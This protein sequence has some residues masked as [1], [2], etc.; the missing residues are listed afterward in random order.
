[1]L[2]NGNTINS[3][4][5]NNDPAWENMEQDMEGQ[6][7]AFDAAEAANLE[8]LDQAVVQEDAMATDTEAA[9][10]A[11]ATANLAESV[12]NPTTS[13][14][15]ITDE[16]LA[17]NLEGLE[18]AEVQSAAEIAAVET[19]PVATDSNTLTGDT[20]DSPSTPETAPKTDLEQVNDIINKYSNPDDVNRSEG[21]P[22]NIRTAD[23][24]VSLFEEIY[25]TLNNSDQPRTLNQEL[26]SSEQK[27]D[28]IAKRY[29]NRGD[30]AHAQ[31]YYDLAKI[32][33]NWAE[34]TAP[35]TPAEAPATN[36]EI[37]TEEA[38]PE[39]APAAPA[40]TPNHDYSTGKPFPE[41]PETPAENPA[42]AQ[43]TDAATTTLNGN[44]I[45]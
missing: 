34:T 12:P 40:L 31:H 22:D 23:N 13:E 17:T 27:Y 1:M 25:D 10:A 21:N 28:R 24:I 3:S 38:T 30:T 9:E 2:E 45:S 8:A 19:A 5:A 7:A 6:T 42:D 39:P 18:Q 32:A 36:T 33:H 44:A 16:T 15:I 35:A 43:S 26:A 41:S 29:E 20:I 11:M 14:E 4:T 37:P